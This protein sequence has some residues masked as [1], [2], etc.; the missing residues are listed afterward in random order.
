MPSFIPIPE[1]ELRGRRLRFLL[2]NGVNETVAAERFEGEGR[3]R[4][5]DGLRARP[6]E[7]RGERAQRMNQALERGGSVF[8]PCDGPYDGRQRQR[9]EG[10][11]TTLRGACQSQK[12]G[13]G[14]H[15]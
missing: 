7:R 10:D 3:R 4:I 9:D 14:I 12:T 6:M 13:G 2:A 8:A 15:E 5:E 11:E 1:M